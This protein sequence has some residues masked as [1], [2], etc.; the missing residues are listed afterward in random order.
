MYILAILEWYAQSTAD[1]R[2]H[3]GRAKAA[4]S[5]VIGYGFSML[6]VRVACTHDEGDACNSGR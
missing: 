1:R 5:A 6:S 3:Q 4:T 2:P